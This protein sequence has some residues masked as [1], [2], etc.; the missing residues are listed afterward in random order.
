M[1]IAPQIHWH[2]GLFLQPHHIQMLQRFVLEQAASERRL[3]FN[4]PW[5][6]TSMRLTPGALEGMTVR[7]EHLRAVMPSGLEVAFPDN[8]DLPVLNI[9]EMFHRGPEKFTVFLGVPTWHGTRANT[10]DHTNGHADWRTARIYRVSEVQRPDENTGQNPQPV[11]VRR[12][13]AR[14]MFEHEDRTDM[15][16]MPLLRVMSGESDQ[17]TRV[18]RVDETYVPPTMLMSGSPELMIRVRE[19]WNYF[20]SRRSRHLETMNRGGFKVEQMTALQLVQFQRLRIYNHYAARMPDLLEAPSLT[21]FEMYI[22]LRGMLG[23][24]ASMFPDRKILDEGRRY[25]HDNPMLVFDEVITQIRNL[26]VGSEDPFWEIPFARDPN[27]KRIVAKLEEKHLTRPT[28]YFLALRMNQGQDPMS[29]KGDVENEVKFKLMPLTEIDN[30]VFGVRLKFELYPPMQ[31]PNRPGMAYYRLTRAESPSSMRMW[32]KIRE[33]GMA[34]IKMP[35]EVG[36][37]IHGISLVM[38]LPPDTDAGS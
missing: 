3:R 37:A 4:Y 16:V 5:G 7:F 30:N 33:Q 35:P 38:T 21:P 32:S 8:A 20:S 1:A 10:L 29:I 36:Q 27:T 17:G 22:E 2:E 9:E 31:L 25:N 28:D 24:L 11:Q 18:P 12:I 6:V 23:E 14:L 15:E 19:L 34:A 26:L 13:N